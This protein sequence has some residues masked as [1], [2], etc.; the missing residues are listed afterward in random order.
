MNLEDL[1]S[2]KSI[3]YDF[4]SWLYADK[5][6]IDKNIELHSEFDI[7]LAP[8]YMDPNIYF[9]RQFNDFFHTCSMQR[10]GRISQLSLAIDVFPNTYNNRLEHSKGAYNRKLEEYLYSFQNENWKNYIE[11]NNL[12]IYIV[13]DLLKISGHDIG[14][15]PLSH[16][17]E[18][19]IYNSHEAHE[20]IGK[21][22]MCEDEEIQAVY[23]SISPD[24]PNVIREL[25]ERDVLNINNHNEGSYDVDRLDYLSRDTLYIGRPEKLLTQKYKRTPVVVDETGRIIE[26]NDGSVIED[27]NSDKFIDVYSYESLCEIEKLLN[28][29]YSMYKNCYMS[30]KTKI[31]ECAIGNFFD[32]LLSSNSSV[33]SE[34]KDFILNLKSQDIRNANLSNFKSWDDI[35]L[36]TVLLDIAENHENKNVRD[37]ATMVIPTMDSLLNMLYSHFNI[38]SKKDF[39]KDDM[40]LLSKIKILIK[41]DS[42]LSRNLKNKNFIGENTL[43]NESGSLLPTSKFISTFSYVLKAYKTKEPIYVKSK[44]GKIYELSK[45]PDRECDW[46]SKRTLIQ[47]QYAYIPYLRLCG[48]S[49]EDINQV[50][51]LF[52]NDLKENSLHTYD[53]S[54]FSPKVNMQQLQVGHKMEDVFLEL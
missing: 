28:L 26:N 13:G 51:L 18:E 15:F 48:V 44:D 20:E 32:A 2:K 41:S 27:K 22:I 1:N 35:K 24:L 36:F 33:G 29:R 46:Q 40:K 30:T 34:L 7:S 3:I 14:H 38:H 10:L 9:P 16:A 39:S 11:N 42:E 8:Y 50:K 43:I 45:H 37:L 49:A 47:A 54:K 25:Y 19:E 5:R 23:K 12:K 31:N 52:K 4:F 53:N 6:I 21:R 17:F